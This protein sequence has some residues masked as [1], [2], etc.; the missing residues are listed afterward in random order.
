MLAWEWATL[1]DVSA[2]WRLFCVLALLGCL[3]FVAYYEPVL[4][5]L[6]LGLGW[7][8]FALLCLVRYPSI[9]RLRTSTA[10]QLLAGLLALVPAW[11]ALH[12]LRTESEGVWL[13]LFMLFIAAFSDMG[14]YFAGRAF[15]R[16]PLAP[17]LSP[18]KTLEGVVGAV[19]ASFFVAGIMGTWLF[20]VQS[21][22]IF[23]ATV[24]L[25]I[26]MSILGD[27][28]ESMMKRI[29]NVKDSGNW[30]PGHGGLLDRG[31]ALIAVAPAMALIVY[32]N[33]FP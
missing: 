5:V 1:A 8:L 9:G 10:L 20:K 26:W 18:S 22:P 32:W 16:K 4:P 27:L 28:T 15:G 31:D 25:L 21:W 33:Y 14:G 2:P 7:W 24:L 29:R 30:L 11:T 23:L 6:I 17:K 12:W 19:F 13:I 3:A